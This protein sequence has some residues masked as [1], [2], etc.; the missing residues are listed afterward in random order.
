MSPSIIV[1]GRPYVRLTLSLFVLGIYSFIPMHAFADGYVMS[2]GS[3]ALSPADAT[4][5]YWC[6][7]ESFIMTGSSAK[8]KSVVPVAGTITK[9]TGFYLD[10]ATLGTNELSTTTLQIN[11]TDM[12]DIAPINNSTTRAEF[13]LTTYSQT[14]SAGDTIQ[15][16]WVTPTW[17][18]NP[19]TVSASA[20]IYIETAPTSSGSTTVA[21]STVTVDMPAFNLLSMILLW[22][23]TATGV[24]WLTR[25]FIL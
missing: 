5:Y 18:T 3:N 24:V 23:L 17:A 1:I 22:V 13:P 25:K 19:T 12:I 11:G 6:K 15:L 16:K 4:S 9:I 14:V 21:T 7:P 10:N 8:L 20:L 2:C